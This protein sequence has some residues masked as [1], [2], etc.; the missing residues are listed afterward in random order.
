MQSVLLGDPAS[1]AALQPLPSILSS[2]TLIEHVFMRRQKPVTATLWDN[3]GCFLLIEAA[4]TL[5]R[6]LKPEVAD[7]RVWV[8][9]GRLHIVPLPSK[10]QPTIPVQPSVS[11]ALSLV[12][13]PEV[14]TEAGPPMPPLHS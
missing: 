10:A 6:W 13:G 2:L 7:R 11:A 4:L 12:R 3:D 5:P 14:P 8:H 9:D 1:S